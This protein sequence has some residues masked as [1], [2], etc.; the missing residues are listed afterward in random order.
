MHFNLHLDLHFI[1]SYHYNCIYIS[2]DTV[3][4][5]H[6]PQVLII[7]KAK[8]SFQHPHYLNISSFL[9]GLQM[10]LS[11]FIYIYA[12]IFKFDLLIGKLPIPILHFFLNYLYILLF[13]CVRALFYNLDITRTHAFFGF[14]VWCVLIY[15][16][17]YIYFLFSFFTIFMAI[18]LYCYIPFQKYC[19]N[20]RSHQVFHSDVENYCTKKL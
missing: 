15:I 6:F 20:L 19:T 1:Y 10:S 7:R 13:L 16:M 12:F 5:S 8:R 11:K 9:L 18:A 14:S 4:K 17:F 2:K 3:K